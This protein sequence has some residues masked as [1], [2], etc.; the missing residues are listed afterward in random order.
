[1]TTRKKPIFEFRSKLQSSGTGGGGHF[2]KV[3]EEVVHS[4][5]AGKRPAVR[6]SFNGI[7]YRGRVVRMGDSYCIGVLKAIIE[8][9]GLRPGGVVDVKLA[10]DDEPRTVEVPPELMAALRKNKRLQ[11][12]WDSL[13]Y[14]HR[15]E[16]ARAIEQAKKP[17][18]KQ[19]RVQ[20]AIDSLTKG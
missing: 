20:Q 6:A 4:L 15:K 7:D 13:S 12:A 18:T 8:E 9:T 16:W 10:L 11:D 1:M 17:E 14:T 19:R 2:V 5:G 3:P